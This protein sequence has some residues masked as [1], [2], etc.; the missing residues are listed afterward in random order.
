MGFTASVSPGTPVSQRFPDGHAVFVRDARKWSPQLL[1]LSLQSV[2]S[3]KETLGCAALTPSATLLWT[4]GWPAPKNSTLILNWNVHVEIPQTWVMRS[5][6]FSWQAVKSCLKPWLPWLL[7]SLIL[8]FETTGSPRQH[9]G[10]QQPTTTMT[11]NP[12][13]HSGSPHYL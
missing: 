5:I 8:W 13:S 10:S 2:A 11:T 4:V 1:S 12:A 6:F 7:L 3:S 9:P